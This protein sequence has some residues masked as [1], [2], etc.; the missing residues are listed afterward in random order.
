[1]TCDDKEV[2]Y[3]RCTQCGKQVSTG[4]VPVPTNT[5]D[6][7]LVVRAAIICPECLEKR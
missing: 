3:L 6:G 5:P 7:G 4:Y 1:M 2:K